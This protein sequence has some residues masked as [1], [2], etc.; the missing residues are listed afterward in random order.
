MKEQW[1]GVTVFSALETTPWTCYC[2]NPRWIKDEYR[3]F[4]HYCH[5]PTRKTK[6]KPSLRAARVLYAAAKRAA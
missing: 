3:N 6:P 1:D 2:Q 4:S 5:T